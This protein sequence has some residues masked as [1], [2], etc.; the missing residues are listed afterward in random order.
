[1]IVI[2][3]VARPRLDRLIPPPDAPRADLSGAQAAV[4]AKVE[5]ALAAVEAEPRSALAWAELAMVYHAHALPIEARTCYAEAARLDPAEPRWPYL[6][7]LVLAPTDPAASLERLAAAQSLGAIGLAVDWHE[8]NLL[9][10]LGRAEEARRA[11]ERGLAHD[12][13]AA[14][15]LAGR[16]RLRLQAGDLEAAVADL[17]AAVRADPNWAES[18][19]LLSQAY[20][21]LRREVDAAAAAKLAGAAQQ[22]EQL[23]PPDPV[24]LTVID[25]G[26][27]VR[28]LVRRG[29]VA[30]QAGR[31]Q[32]AE[33]LF[34]QAI[35]ADPAAPAGYLGLGA[36]LQSRGDLAG[37]IG[38]YRQALEQR[39]EDVEALANLG[40]ALARSGKPDE[41]RTQLTTALALAPGHLGASLNLSLV[42]L[43]EGDPAG[44][45]QTV[46]RALVWQP[47]ERQLLELRANA[48]T[49]LGRPA[50][51]A[52]TWRSVVEAAAADPQPLVRWA[53]ALMQAGDHAQA[54][55]VLR[56]G[57][58]TFPGDTLLQA[59][60][61]WQ[62]ATA[63]D[64][65]LRDGEES[66]S[67]ARRLVQAM[68]GSAQAQD[69]LATALAETGDWA[70]AVAAAEGAV[71]ALQAEDP[72]GDQIRARL[73]S[74]RE[75]RPFRQ[76][77]P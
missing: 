11:F 63:P 39:P 41:G 35:S 75:G 5:T 36:T 24:F 27:S 70:G 40:L 15:L 31:A 56:R 48:L 49:A 29:Q 18:Y 20:G 37:A 61:A 30:A 77:H 51:A 47:A 12:P 59:S 60:L 1:M 68:P 7:A 19:V 42:L 54:L 38:Q 26:V 9:A 44:A 10:E 57:V 22:L 14:P 13:M 25:R 58:S 4:R 69:V 50:E 71:A 2:V 64:A 67:L 17:E 43:E 45:L 72:A 34:R 32:E 52:A 16:G 21:R 33:A 65:A 73:A 23:G 6:E 66:V 76:E 53:T 28:W 55:T 46:D 74:F 8:G 3:I 62:L